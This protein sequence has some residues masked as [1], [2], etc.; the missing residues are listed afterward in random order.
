MRRERS[1]RPDDGV[2]RLERPHSR[3]DFVSKTRVGRLRNEA[4]LLLL[5]VA[6]LQCWCW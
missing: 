5:L 1:H 2:V 4:S 6:S 3:L